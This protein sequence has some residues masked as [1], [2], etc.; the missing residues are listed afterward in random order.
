[1]INSI[2]RFGEKGIKDLE[3][4]V[5]LFIQNPTDISGFV[6]GMQEQVLKLALDI[7]A[8]TFERYDDELRQSQKRKQ[9]WQIVRRDTKT[10]ITSIGEISFKKTLFKNKE[11][12]K[13]NYLID[14][15]LGLD[16]HERLTED[17]Q[18]K[19]LEEAVESSYRKGGEKTSILTSVSKQTVK[20][21]I[22]DL[23][24]PRVYEPLIEKKKVE[25]LYLDADEDHVSLQF[26]KIKGDICQSTTGKT[27]SQIA[28]LVYAYEGIKPEAPKSKR[29]KLI[30]PR[31]FSGVYKG[32]ANKELWGEVY[33]YLDNTYDLEHVKKIYL[34]S[35]GGT[36]IDTQGKYLGKI[37]HILDEFHISKYI[38][39]ATSH[40]LDS[41]SDARDEI[42]QA[43]RN[44]SRKKLKAVE[45]KILNATNN[46]TIARRV[47]ESIKYLSSNMKAIELR[48]NKDDRVIGCSAEGHV[49]H[50]LSSR[51]SSRPLGWSVQ[52]VEQMSRLRAYYW[53]KEDMLKLVRYQKQE[54]P[55]AVGCE[56]LILSSMQVLNNQPETQKE[57]RKYFD[58]TNKTLQA[59]QVS[60]KAWFKSHIW[61]L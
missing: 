61:D 47:K 8:E 24:F 54:M 34:N 11:T 51:M 55:K 26:H 46:E 4:V 1:M 9:R 48:L 13:R 52:G 5:D 7:I 6:I 32:D 31:Y 14:Q 50:V 42:Y 27:N 16:S 44:G 19:M 49:S 40:L 22:H 53:N 30:K 3:K 17:A 59:N 45:G 36:W 18:V 43:L 39:R 15:V 37:T 60:K 35:D 56:E 58:V 41:T 12:G 2:Q 38:L 23:K 33:K 29:N 21:K 10:L 28:K 25:Y 20:N 57:L